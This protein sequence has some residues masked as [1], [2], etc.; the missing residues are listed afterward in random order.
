MGGADKKLDFNG[1][2]YDVIF[3]RAET[4]KTCSCMMKQISYN[5]NCSIRIS[6]TSMPVSLLKGESCAYKVFKSTEGIH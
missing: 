4:K 2:D 5:D 1:E 3:I 6:N